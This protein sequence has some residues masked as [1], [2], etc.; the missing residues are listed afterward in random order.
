[1]HRPAAQL[2]AAAETTAGI[3]VL[4]ADLVESFQH[5][6]SDA[7]DDLPAHVPFQVVF[8]EGLLD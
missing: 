2:E 8:D 7:R 6:F 5:S 3:L 1:V 4:S